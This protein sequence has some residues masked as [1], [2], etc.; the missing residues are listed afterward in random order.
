MYRGRIVESARTAALFDQPHHPYT[1]ALL[2]AVP[3][4]DPEARRARI[5][6]DGSGVDLRAPLR[7]VAPGH[8]AAL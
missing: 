1:R 7:E 8:F 2:S 6:F 3:V 5:E 4:P